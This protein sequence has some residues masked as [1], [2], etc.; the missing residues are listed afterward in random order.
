MQSNKVYKI[1]DLI[2]VYS[3]I[4]IIGVDMYPDVSLFFFFLYNTSNTIKVVGTKSNVIELY[5][6]SNKVLYARVP[7]G[8]FSNVHFSGIFMHS[9]EEINLPS[10]VS[11]L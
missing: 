11:K 5:I 6:D 2:N 9:C 3:Y 8:S 1:A 7:L 4:H 10:G